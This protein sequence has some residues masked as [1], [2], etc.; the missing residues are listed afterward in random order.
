MNERPPEYEAFHLN[1]HET[2]IV[3]VTRDTAP[4]NLCVKRE[5]ERER[6]KGAPDRHTTCLHSK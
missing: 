5:R 4:I 1:V 6:E 2:H 3:T